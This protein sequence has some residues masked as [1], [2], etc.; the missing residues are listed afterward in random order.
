MEAKALGAAR[1]SGE[2]SSEKVAE[3]LDSGA[4]EINGATM[5]LNSTHAAG[6]V[7]AN[8]VSA[9]GVREGAGDAAGPTAEFHANEW[10]GGG[11]GAEVGIAAKDVVNREH[12]VVKV[13]CLLC[14]RCVSIDG[15][16]LAWCVLR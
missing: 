5:V 9:P 8:G 13:S 1:V 7:N 4:D 12:A 6:E 15:F 11:E 10:R 2:R 3:G 16:I 14:L